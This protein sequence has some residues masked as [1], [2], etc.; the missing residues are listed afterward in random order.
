MFVY[1]EASP[2]PAFEG[3][4]LE[5]ITLDLGASK[6]DVTVFVTERESALELAVEYREDRFDERWMSSMLD[7]YEALLAGLAENRDRPTAETPLLSD[8]ELE[9]ITEYAQ[10]QEAKGKHAFLPEQ[11]REQA[12]RTPSAPAVTCGGTSYTYSELMASASAVA[13]ELAR[14]D[15][16]GL[17][18]DRSV[19]MIAGALGCHLAGAAYVPLDP[20]Y[21]EK[22]NHDVLDDADATA[23]L[24]TSALRA[25]LP[26]GSWTTIDVDRSQADESSRAIPAITF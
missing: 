18:L 3:T 9:R 13:S 17:F 12:Q 19:L 25:R 10:G 6:F 23:V 11:I 7:H 16:V 14:G 24:T 20:S 22:R 8:A 21:P 5:P 1:Q 2:L 15:R 4:R 26:Q